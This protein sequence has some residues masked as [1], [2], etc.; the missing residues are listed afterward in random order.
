MKRERGARVLGSVSGGE[1]EGC[2]KVLVG[3]TEQ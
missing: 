1:K 2:K 3:E